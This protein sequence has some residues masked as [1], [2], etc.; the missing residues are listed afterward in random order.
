MTLYINLLKK[1]V[2]DAKD[3]LLFSPNT[4]GTLYNFLVQD[5][6]EE[7]N[8]NLPI[9]KQSKQISHIWQELGT[10]KTHSLN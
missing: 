1:E 3:G 9:S 8:N 5:C 4:F 7:Y 6:G 10:K 2:E